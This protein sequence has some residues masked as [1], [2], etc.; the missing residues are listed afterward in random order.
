MLVFSDC[1]RDKGRMQG[2]FL[3]RMHARV[4][5]S[6]MR[7]IYNLEIM[8]KYTFDGMP[9]HNNVPCAPQIERK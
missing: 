3:K 4:Y 6:G 2:P 9:I 5:G 8:Y 1:D 7:A